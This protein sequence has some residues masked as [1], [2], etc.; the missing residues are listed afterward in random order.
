MDSIERVRAWRACEF[1]L[2]NPQSTD[3]PRNPL[4][5]P[6]AKI[7]QRLDKREEWLELHGERPERLPLGPRRPCECC[8][9]ESG[10]TA[11][12]LRARAEDDA[13]R[14]VEGYS[15]DGVDTDETSAQTE[16]AMLGAF[17][18]DGGEPE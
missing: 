15:P 7:I 5:E 11:A 14:L 16:E 9:G 1:R 4:E 10:V 2:A 18:T 12:D 6:R 3:T 17:A 13:W 8:D